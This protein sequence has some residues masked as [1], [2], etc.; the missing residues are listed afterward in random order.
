MIVNKHA[1]RESLTS[2]VEVNPVPSFSIF[3][4]LKGV[5]IMIKTYKSIRALCNFIGFN[6]K[7]VSAILNNSKINNYNYNFEYAKEGPSTIEMVRMI[8][9]NNRVE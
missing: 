1:N 4:L 5:N 7:T 8:N 3:I 6:R 2:K 9:S